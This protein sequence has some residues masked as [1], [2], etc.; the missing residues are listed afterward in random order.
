M[1]N[2]EALKSKVDPCTKSGK[3][4]MANSVM[5]TRCGKWM[6]GGCAKIKRVTLTLAK[7]FFCEVCLYTKE[8]IVE[9]S[10]EMS[11]LNR[12]SLCYLVDWLNVSGG[13]EA[14]VTAS[15]NWMDFHSF[16]RM[17][18]CSLCMSFV[19]L[20]HHDRLTAWPRYLSAT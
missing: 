3:R 4:L 16:T 20:G 7:V 9:S 17:S 11:L 10:E 12:L 2:D 18:P 19:R 15:T 8:G 6:H 1:V 5:C 13:S 14:A